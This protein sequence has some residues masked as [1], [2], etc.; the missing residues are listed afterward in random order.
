[1]ESQ[2]IIG[3]SM[4]GVLGQEFSSSLCKYLKIGDFVH[5]SGHCNPNYSNAN[6][7]INMIDI[8][9]NQVIVLDSSMYF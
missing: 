9:A 3:K 6:S 5:I 1:M 2:V 8:L 7:D 4:I